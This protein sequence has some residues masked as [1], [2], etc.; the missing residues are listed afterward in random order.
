MSP[1]RLRIALAQLNPTLGDVPR[2]AD[3]VRLARAAAAADGA[4]LLVC[5][6]LALLGAPL[7]DLGRDDVLLDEAAAALDALCQETADGGPAI[8]LGLP[9][10]PAPGATPCNAVALLA[11]GRLVGWRAKTVLS[12]AAG[13]DEPRIF[14]PGPVPGPIALPRDDGAPIRLGVIVGTDMESPDVAEAL[15]ETGA[16]VLI[17]VAAAPFA[18]DQFD[19]R[20]QLAVQRVAETGLPLVLVNAWGGQDGIVFEG[21]SFALDADCR[22][23]ALAPMFQ[24]SLLATGWERHEDGPLLPT[25][26]AGRTA[27]WEGPAAIYRA[28]MLGLADQALKGGWTDVSVRLDGSLASLLT[29]LIAADSVGP[30]RVHALAMPGPSTSRA[31]LNDAIA[32]A[33]RLGIDVRT[34]PIAPVL[35]SWRELMATLPGGG[36]EASDS[37]QLHHAI[38]A[39]A[40]WQA[41]WMLLDIS[42][43]P[44]LALGTTLPCGDLAV[45]GDLRQADLKDLASW[46]QAHNSLPW[47]IDGADLLPARLLDQEDAVAEPTLAEGIRQRRAAPPVV[48][49]STTSFGHDRRFPAAWRRSSSGSSV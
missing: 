43:R 14:A 5:P 4:D 42:T 27:P 16:E 35:D 47:A 26:P 37:A 2:N 8:L 24:A 49:L 17:V 44:D 48:R 23:V 20:Q 33:R 13:F 21:A 10:R 32:A 15:A 19:V 3:S 29:I 12:W 25:A 28:V 6:E 34:V 38:L 39:A 9:L 41:G 7:G 1:T 31:D 46:R 36:Q 11:G 40:A 22:L 45:L 30:S 18:P